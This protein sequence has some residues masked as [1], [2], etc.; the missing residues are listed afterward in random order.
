MWRRTMCGM[1]SNAGCGTN[2]ASWSIVQP[3]WPSLFFGKGCPATV[4]G[5]LLSEP[6][7]VIFFPFPTAF[8]KSSTRYAPSY[9]APQVMES[10]SG[11]ILQVSPLVG[12]GLYPLT[13]PLPAAPLAPAA[14]PADGAPASPELP[15]IGGEPPAP[16]PPP[17]KMPP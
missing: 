8:A 1:T 5:P 15:P 12:H 16:A 6:V 10:P 14:P 17:P 11:N 9:W 2:P 13:P 7:N 4:I 3:L